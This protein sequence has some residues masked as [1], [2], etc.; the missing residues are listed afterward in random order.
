MRTEILFA[1]INRCFPDGQRTQEFIFQLA[2]W[3]DEGNEKM[4]MKS[5]D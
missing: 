4:R 5:S 2:G 1:G 3:R